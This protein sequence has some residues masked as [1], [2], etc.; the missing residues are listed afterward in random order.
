[1]P[2]QFTGNTF[3]DVYRDDW[4]DSDGY[5][6][7]LFN[8]GRP[9]QA[10]ELTTLQTI[11][12]EQITKFASNI[13]QDGAAVSTPSGGAL[14]APVDYVIV[15]D[16]GNVPAEDYVGV[17]LQ[18]PRISGVTSGVQFQVTHVLEENAGEEPVLYGRYISSNQATENSDVQVNNNSLKF[19]DGQTLS[20]VRVGSDLDVGLSPL[21]VRTRP[22]N[23]QLQ[24]VGRGSRFAL[25]GSDFFTQ[26]HFVYAES[27]SI[28][29]GK[30]T[31][32]PALVE[33]GFQVVQDII[34]VTDTEDLYDN[35]GA[36]P[37]LSSPGADR[38]R[39]KLILTTREAA[40]DEQFVSFAV[41]RNGVII[42]QKGDDEGFNQVEKRMAVRHKETNGDFVASDFLMR[43]EESGDSTKLELEVPDKVNGV[44]PIAYVDGFRLIHEYPYSEAINKPLSFTRDSDAVSG[45]DYRNYITVT[46]SDRFG[47]YTGTELDRNQK[48][49]MFDDA[50][51]GNE[52]GSCRIKAFKYNG[53]ANNDFARVYLF[54]VKMND[55][56]NFR[57]VK[58][59]ANMASPGDRFTP[60]LED[61]QLFAQEPNNNDSLFM[62]PGGRVKEVRD[63]N[64]AVQRSEIIT[65]VGTNVQV[66]CNNGE[67][68][69]DEGQW[70]IHNV[71][72]GVTETTLPGNINSVNQTSDITVATSGAEYLVSYY[73]QLTNAGAKVK[74][75]RREEVEFTRVG[76]T[77]TFT[78][79]S[80]T[81]YDGIEL[82][83]ARDSDSDGSNLLSALEFDG[84]QRDNYYGP[85]ELRGDDVPASVTTVKTH[86]TYFDWQAGGNYFSVESYDLSDPEFGY[87][88]IPTYQVRSTGA[89]VP[90]HDVFDFRTKLDPAQN[91]MPDLD[92]FDL[93]RDGDSIRYDVDFYNCRV[94]KLELTYDENTF[95]REFNYVYG[96]EALSPVEKQT[97]ENS[98]A[99]YTI[100]LNGNTKSTEDLEI[101]KHRLPRYRMSEIND[102]EQRVAR[103]EET[104]SLTFLESEAINHVEFDSEGSVRARTGFFADDFT[105]AYKFAASAFTPE[106]IDDERFINSSWDEE[107][108][109]IYS[110]QG[111]YESQL[112]FDADALPTVQGRSG[113]TKSNVVVKGD[114]LMLEYVDVLDPTMSQELISWRSDTGYEE[115]GYYN[116]NPYNVFVGEGSL[117]IR[118]SRDSWVDTRRLPDNV[119]N[120]GTVRRIANPDFRPR[121]FSVRR[122]VRFFATLPFKGGFRTGWWIR[123][124]T[125]RVTP[126]VRTRVIGDEMVQT[127]LGTTRVGLSLIPFARQKRIVGAAEGLRPFTRYWLYFAG[128]DVSQWT[129]SLPDETG[130]QNLIDAGVQNQ[131]YSDVNVNINSHPFGPGAGN[132]LTTDAYGKLWFD[133]WLPN[134]APV[135]TGKN[136]DSI[137]EWERYINQQRRLAR[138]YGSH[139]NKNVFNQLG[140]K[141]RSGSQQ[142]KLL[143]VSD[144]AEDNALSR[145]RTTFTSSGQLS[146]SQRNILSTRV[147]T[148]ERFQETPQDDPWPWGDPL[149]QTFMVD[150]SIGVPGV[151]VTKIDTFIRSAPRT[152]ANE[153]TDPGIP[154]QLQ[155]RAVENGV[156]LSG[157]ISPQHRVYKSADEVY[158]VVATIKAGGGLEDLQTV[159][160]NPVTFEFPEPIYLRS[161][162]EYA[163]VLLAECDAYEAFVA[164]TY[165]LLLGETNKR[166]SKQPTMGSLFLSQNG[167]TW[168]PK[169]NQDLAYR[170]Y[171]AKFKDQGTANLYNS[172]LTTHVHNWDASLV[173]DGDRFFV[174]HTAHGL[175]VGDPVNL[176]GLDPTTDYGGGVTGSNIMDPA[177]VVDSADIAGYWVRQ[178]GGSTFPEGTGRFGASTV[179]TDRGF[180]ID[181][182]SMVLNTIS[183]PQTDIS[184]TGS[185]IT[186]FSHSDVSLTDTQDPRFDII[187]QPLANRFYT[188]F[189]KPRYIASEAVEQDADKGRGE[190]SIVVGVNM[191][192]NQTSS[193]GGDAALQEAGNGYVSDMS[194]IL[195]MQSMS[196]H[197]ENNLV[198]NQ[199][200][201]SDNTAGRLNTNT[202]SVY[203]PE[204]HPTNGTAASKYITKVIA[205]DQAANSVRVFLELNRPPEA[206]VDLYFRST[207]TTDEDIYQKE[208]IYIEGD[209]LP[210]ANPEN[211]PQNLEPEFSEYRYLVGGDGTV[212]PDF[213]AFQIKVV[214]RATNTTQAPCMKSIRAIAVV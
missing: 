64:Y 133:F 196:M 128:V 126:A 61:G 177:N 203:V 111:V 204:T 14:I 183:L 192:T 173:A 97:S 9:L 162:V 46:D 38:Y 147:I 78:P 167:S 112:K 152:A 87:S 52:I 120:G 149:A 57:E 80:G 95:V 148:L 33:V 6:R 108:N 86:I 79:T 82:L 54:D 18:G 146:V 23:S 144:N 122:N 43:Y 91:N 127:D 119:I 85:I 94:D 37:N 187:N 56:E 117:N 139:K 90:L 211:I 74:N 68:F 160:D 21:T 4:K 70:V 1:M 121:T 199:P 165:D 103:L 185:F 195:D 65:A 174:S 76:A 209:N 36:R 107:T 106:F 98:I 170:I 63:V 130:Y 214:F 93:P 116:V 67:S 24:S 44:N 17:V 45:V 29:I 105:G 41:V 175:G 157:V 55:G 143:D 178:A 197:F 8:S 62:I 48:H 168:T 81:M 134:N 15:T 191:T 137:A 164:T 201:D 73:V 154:L 92:H 19:S 12:Q 66:R 200:L 83:W 32:T 161:G 69:I 16:L 13:F 27:Q 22:A 208:W 30:Y 166:V 182:L 88:D 142:M 115:R 151:F 102:L 198:D 100:M 124:T 129:L 34:S 110:K 3:K 159:L 31:D 205:L 184:Y 186:G 104:I 135:P 202:P 181:G 163:I 20:D 193:F 2:Q 213:S 176:T 132:V 40:G 51:S 150:G 179:E 72:D 7:V 10:R 101:Q 141:F 42:N 77:S 53:T 5:H 125:Q 123:R 172:A 109:V 207:A 136:F 156:P 84:G 180:N 71:D 114:T 39:I 28:I 47:D 50:V 145:A 96:D 75:Y 206:G 58:S 155:I 140:W 59:I 118:P 11:L 158:D 194:P 113:L 25:Q 89:L 210:R 153:G 212:L 35:Q 188:T 190:P 169:Q 99:L 60:Y 138:I 189:T 131:N 49:L 26:G 171:T